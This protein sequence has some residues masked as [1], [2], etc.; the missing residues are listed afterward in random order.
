MTR[1]G[2]LHVI[3][4]C[5]TYTG[6]AGDICT[7]TSSNLEEIEVGSRVVYAKAEGD[8][9]LDTDIVL[10]VGPGNTAAGHV[11]LDLA[12][13]TGVVT[14]SGGSGK[15]AGLQGRADV[16]EDSAGLWHWEGTYSF[17]SAD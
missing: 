9:R 13:G 11:V 14:F 1:R 16:W 8:G 7:I 5:S 12:G 17:D 6:L 15:L 3:K 4:E 10:E 2:E